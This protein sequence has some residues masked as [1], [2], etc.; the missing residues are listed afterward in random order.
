MTIKKYALQTPFHFGLEGVPIGN[1]FSAVTDT[2][3][4]QTL[5]AA[6]NAG[7]RYYDVSPWYGLG[8]AE[9]RWT[10]PAQSKRDDY[11]ISSKV[12]KLLKASK[13]PFNPPYRWFTNTVS[14]ITRRPACA[15]PLKTVFS[16]WNRQP[17][18]CF[19]PRPVTRQYIPT[20]MAGTFEIANKVL[21]LN[22]SICVKKV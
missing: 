11:V 14:L 5:E 6:W 8:L 17:R 1:E 13:M 3:A 16:A 20:E 10:F 18:Y 21:S 9:R 22:L 4:D 2:D 15:V 19:C 12:G 7:I